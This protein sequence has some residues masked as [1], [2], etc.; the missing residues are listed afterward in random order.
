M[1]FSSHEGDLLGVQPSEGEHSNLLDNVTPISRCTCNMSKGH[2][3]VSE[4][5]TDILSPQ[6]LRKCVMKLKVN[7]M[8]FLKKDRKEHNRT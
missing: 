1:V 7:F 8:A 4:R 3:Y 2:E 6:R 5:L